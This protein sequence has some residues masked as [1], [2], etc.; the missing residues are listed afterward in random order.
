V[1]AVNENSD[2]LITKQALGTGAILLT[3]PSYMQSTAQNGILEIC[4]QLLDSLMT[5]YSVVSIAGPP[6]E[7]VVSQAPG[8]I[9]VTVVNNSGTDWAGTITVV[10]QNAVTS[11]AEYTAD[12]PVE[13]AAS[14]AG[15]AVPGQVPAYGVRVFGIEYARSTL[16]TP[17]LG[18]KN[19]F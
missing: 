13:F 6:V 12:Q 16:T 11:V 19:N 9:V 10:P 2:P 1:L 3:T 18:K 5:K 8:N 17:P 4:T 14:P 7:Y 15:A